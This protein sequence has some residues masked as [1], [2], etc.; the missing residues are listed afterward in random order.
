MVMNS[1]LGRL[2]NVYFYPF[3]SHTY[4]LYY[5]RYDVARYLAV[6]Y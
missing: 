4:I 6:I 3:T 1:I 2:V 5:T